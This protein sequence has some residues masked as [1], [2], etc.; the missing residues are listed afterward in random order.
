MTH[1]RFRAK[2]EAA[3][4]G[5][6][7][8]FFFVTSG[9][10]FDLHALLADASALARVPVFV[11]ALLAARGAPAL[12]YRARIGARRAAAAGLL[13][14]TSLGLFVVASQIGMDLGVIDKATGAALVAAGMLSVL[15]FPT[16]AAALLRPACARRWSRT[17]ISAHEL[18]GA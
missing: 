4:F 5:V 16:T 13:Q 14:A 10:R 3:G 6:F 15:V 8:P 17:G 1:P 9:V 12:L 2:L 11:L 7:V 18:E